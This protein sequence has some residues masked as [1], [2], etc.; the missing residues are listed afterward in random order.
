MRVLSRFMPDGMYL[1]ALALRPKRL[2]K[3]MSEIIS[4][5]KLYYEMFR[6]RRYYEYHAAEEHPD[7]DPVCIFCAYL[8]KIE[9]FQK[10]TMYSDIARW[11]NEY[12]DWPQDHRLKNVSENSMIPFTR[13][14]NRT[15]FTKS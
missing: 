11:F 9:N 15:F 3:K 14:L 13:R 1:N 10:I 8:N 5:K 6:W 7:S 12:S 4:N 2:A